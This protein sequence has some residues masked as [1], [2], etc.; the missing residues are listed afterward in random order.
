MSYSDQKFV[1]HT[2]ESAA[3]YLASFECSQNLFFKIILK[4]SGELVGTLTVYH[5]KNH[6]VADI[7]ILIGSKASQG[8]GIGLDAWVT[9]V[10]WLKNILKVRKITAGAMRSNKKMIKIIERSGFVLE[11]CREGQVFDG[12]PEDILYFRHK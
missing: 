12:K 2:K 5:D 3:L 4:E 9:C 1:S 10:N 11:A 7:G 6:G 8:K